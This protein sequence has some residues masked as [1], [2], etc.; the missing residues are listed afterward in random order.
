[1]VDPVVDPEGNSYER[2]AILEWLERSHT[3]PI[4][5]TPLTPEQ[6]IPNRALQEL[7]EV[8]RGSG[9]GACPSVTREERRAA[10]NAAHVKVENA[11][12]ETRRLDSSTA[13]KM[14]HPS[15]TETEVMIS[16]APPRGVDRVPLDLCLV[17]DTSGS[18]E[19]LAT[20]GEE[21]D[22][23]T[24]LDIVKHGVNHHSPLP[25]LTNS[26][27]TGKHGISCSRRK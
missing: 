24:L 1:M 7:L 13:L 10:V 18:M 12:E 9:S 8:A 14:A 6:L 20:H 5:R 16:V 26:N 3:S 21:T 19:S 25:V 15:A 27:H 22:G 4:T 23:L 11:R 2:T 17:I